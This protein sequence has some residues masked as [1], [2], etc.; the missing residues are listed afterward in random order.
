[1]QSHLNRLRV[2]TSSVSV[3]ILLGRSKYAQCLIW[4]YLSL[5]AEDELNKEA[6]GH[7]QDFPEEMIFHMSNLHLLDSVGQ[8]KK[9]CDHVAY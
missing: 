4:T 2:N 6:T 1:M 7:L 9:M 3:V 8:G 5:R